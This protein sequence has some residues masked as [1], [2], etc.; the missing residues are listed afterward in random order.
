[1][2]GLYNGNKLKTKLDRTNLKLHIYVTAK[3]GPIMYS[4]YSLRKF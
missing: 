4:K 3:I 1:M 2:S